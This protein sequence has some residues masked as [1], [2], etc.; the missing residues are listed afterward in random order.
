MRRSIEA[1]AF[2]QSHRTVIE[3]LEGV[4]PI[5]P[6]VEPDIPEGTRLVDFT[7]L[8]EFPTGQLALQTIDFMNSFL[9]TPTVDEETGETSLP[10]NSIL[11]NPLLPLSLNEFPNEVR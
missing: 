2:D 7:A 8:D 6:E 10:I 11:G 4:E 9:G 5:F 3:D 1:P